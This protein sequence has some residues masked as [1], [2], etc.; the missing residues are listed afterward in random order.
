MSAAVMA[1]LQKR[2]VGAKASGESSVGGGKSSF[3][4]AS[5]ATN[6]CRHKLDKMASL[7]TEGCVPGRVP[8]MSMA[9]VE[10]SAKSSKTSWIGNGNPS[11]ATLPYRFWERAFAYRGNS[12]RVRRLFLSRASP[13][14]MKRKHFGMS[15]TIV[16]ASSKPK[17]VSAHS[18]FKNDCCDGDATVVGDAPVMG[19]S[20]PSTR[21]L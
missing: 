8:V 20:I 4:P 19:S 5:I 11:K 18:E 9:S 12:S 17:I 7:S 16:N 15:T 3:L 14:D 13:I 1:V 2:K 10:G 21:E 6:D